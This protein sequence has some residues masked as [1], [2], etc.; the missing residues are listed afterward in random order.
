M[1]FIFELADGW[2]DRY[3]DKYHI[4]TKPSVSRWGITQI[5][6][7]FSL[8]LIATAI[9]FWALSFSLWGGEMVVAGWVCFSLAIVAFGTGIFMFCYMIHWGGK[10]LRD[11]DPSPEMMALKAIA[12]KLGADIDNASE[13]T[14]ATDEQAGSESDRTVENK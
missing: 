10:W 8:F 11:Q 4:S 12:E 6:L 1:R 5:V 9:A 13:E 3:C 14:G 2:V 7:G